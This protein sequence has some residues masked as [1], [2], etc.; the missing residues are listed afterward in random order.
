MQK[1]I[2]RLFGVVANIKFP[3]PI[4]NF[5]NKKYIQA[6]KINMSEFL[7][8]NEYKSLN[9]LFTR[10]LIKNREFSL[11]GVDFISPS[12]SLCLESGICKNLEAISVKGHKY[13]VSE[14]LDETMDENDKTKNLN[15]ANLYLS[16]KDYHHYHAPC[17]LQIL[18]ACYIPAK[19]YSVAKKYLIKIPNLYAKN[20][21]VILK[22]KMPN[23]G[24]LWLV[25]VGALN[26]G[27]MKFDFD[28][29]IQTNAKNAK[30]EIYKYE[31]LKVKKGEHLGNFELGSTI[32]IIGEKEFLNFKIQKDENI[33][34]SQTIAKIL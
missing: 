10:K 13:S 16:P 27:K 8:Y 11:N 12:D 9:E 17:D 4:Q 28:E 26:V 2:S 7:P 18:E 34:F 25:F 15:Y 29:R 19:L 23:G 30:K 3:T 1:Q 21:R 20:E 6:F 32:V 24:S 22:C 5:I 31:N 14:M 33:K